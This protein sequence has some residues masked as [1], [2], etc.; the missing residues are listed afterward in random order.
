MAQK[1]LQAR[2]VLKSDSIEKLN[3]ASDFV[4]L[5]GE[6]IVYERDANHPVRI[7][8]GDGVTNVVDLPFSI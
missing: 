6:L 3:V 7:K 4:P 2:V 1:E 5:A 8:V